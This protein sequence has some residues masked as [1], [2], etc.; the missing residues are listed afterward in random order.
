[1]QFVKAIFYFSKQ[2]CTSHRCTN[3]FMCTAWCKIKG[4]G[5][6]RLFHDEQL[7]RQ[8]SPKMTNR[9]LSLSVPL[10]SIE[11]FWTGCID[12]AVNTTAALFR[13]LHAADKETRIQNIQ[14]LCDKHTVHCMLKWF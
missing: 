12:A 14:G 7:V 13:Y 5:A 8:H 3:K 11:K 2:N 4:Y 9:F 10:L 1:M 6:Q